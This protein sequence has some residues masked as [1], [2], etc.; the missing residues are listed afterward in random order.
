M[1]SLILKIFLC[2]W[3]AAFC[4]IVA[5]D[6]FAHE[7]MHR[8]EV[9][10]ALGSSLRLQGRGLIAAY[11]AGGCRAA[12][13]MM[14][15]I[16]DRIYLAGPDGTVYCDTPPAASDLRGL[17]TRASRSSVPVASNFR[18]FEMVALPV[19][20]SSGKPYLLL[21]KSKYTMPYNLLGSP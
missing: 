2:Y 15:G 19:T 11:E 17:A 16:E 10:V 3:V 9:A 6:L 1:R 8:P 4:V 7:Q 13:P 5:T 14:V 18:S 12:R 20:G 21:L